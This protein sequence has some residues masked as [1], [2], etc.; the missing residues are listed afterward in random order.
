[1][2]K[3]AALLTGETK[4]EVKPKKDLGGQSLD[5]IIKAGKKTNK[6]G[7]GRGKRK[8]RGRGRGRGIRKRGGAQF[9]QGMYRGRGFYTPGY[10]QMQSRGGGRM[11]TP[12]QQ[13]LDE[14]LQIMY[15][16]VQKHHLNPTIAVLQTSSDHGRTQ[17]QVQVDLDISVLERK[18]AGSYG[19]RQLAWGNSKQDAKRKAVSQMMTHP[20]LQGLI[21][22][23]KPGRIKGGYQQPGASALFPK[24]QQQ[25]KKKKNNNQKQKKK[26]QNKQKKEKKEDFEYCWDYTQKTCNKGVDKCKWKHEI[27]E[28]LWKKNTSRAVAL[29]EEYMTSHGKLLTFKFTED[30]ENED[31]YTAICVM[32]GK[33]EG[34]GTGTRFE[35][36]VEASKKTYQ[37]FLAAKNAEKETEKKAAEVMVT[38]ETGE[39][40]E[41]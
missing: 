8:G 41:N 10:R 39:T 14:P 25:K 38:E 22:Q 20:A 15:Q 7:R 27:P 23:L 37:I 13:Q 30:A 17:V 24:A 26:G 36:K 2:T 6:R 9:I 18:P 35:A 3:D 33:D 40:T 4:A 32:D 31:K 1:M 34:E 12:T 16:L 29:F 28:T 5:D 19:L 11:H 21:S